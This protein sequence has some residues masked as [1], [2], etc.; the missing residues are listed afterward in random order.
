MADRSPGGVVSQELRAVLV[1]LAIL[2]VGALGWRVLFTEG[3]GDRLVVHEVA[4]SVRR[5]DGLGKG[6]SAEAGMSLSESDRLVAGEGGRAVLAIGLETR[7]TVEE[8]SAI[9][10]LG[11]NEGGVRLELEEGRVRANVR[12]GSGRVGIVSD[13]REASTADGAFAAG[14]SEDGTFAVASERG[15]VELTGIEGVRSV[16]EG[17]RIVAPKGASPLSGPVSDAL[18]LDVAWPT[19][20][21]TREEEVEVTG[22]TEPGARVRLGGNGRWVT[23]VAGRDGRFVARVSLA[24]GENAVEVQATSLLGTLATVDA[25]ITRDTTAPA[26]GIELR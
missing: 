18:L 1:L 26:I 12:R 16:A 9:R 4:G 25:A 22:T 7:I 20:R 24:E 21:R 5:V 23:V 13:D 8:R 11:V 3:V 10:V 6:E 17:Q 14:V 15:V 2:A 19:A